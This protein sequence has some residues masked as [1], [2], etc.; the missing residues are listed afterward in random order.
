MEENKETSVEK[1]QD[2]EAP[3][4][5][6]QFGKHNQA[7]FLKE[8]DAD[9]LQ[10]LV[11]PKCGHRHFRHAG[12]VLPVLPFTE[13]QEAKVEVHQTAVYLCVKCKSSIITRDGKVHDVSKYI[14]VKAWAKMEEVV[15][16]ETGPGGEC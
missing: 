8:A 10:L 2:G 12:Y 13:K 15:H 9:E 6:T 4:F 16:K 5:T 7:E 3:Q 11:C 14:D 1:H